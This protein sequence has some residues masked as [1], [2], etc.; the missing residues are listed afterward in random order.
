MVLVCVYS[1]VVKYIHEFE[2][3]EHG[4][5]VVGIGNDKLVLEF[6]LQIIGVFLWRSSDKVD[7]PNVG[8]SKDRHAGICAIGVFEL[9]IELCGKV[10]NSSSNAASLWTNH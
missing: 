9:G 2:L 5:I 8:P 7:V 10:S 6:W 3:E 4:T 1:K